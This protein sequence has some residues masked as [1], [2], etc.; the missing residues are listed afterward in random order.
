[1]AVL[2]ALSSPTP[3]LISDYEP[4]WQLQPI[5]GKVVG[6]S[7]GDTITVLDAAKQQHKIRLEGIDAPESNQDYGSRA[8]QSLSDLVFGKVV[9]VTISKKDKY[10]RTLGRVTL[11]GKD[12]GQEQIKRGM[13][14]FYRAYQAELPEN[15]AAMYELGEVRAKA[16]KRGLWA[17]ASPI[18]PWDFRRGKTAKAPGLKPTTTATG[19]IIGNRNSKIYHL[20]NCPDYSKVSE[21]N[22]VPFK[23]EAEAQAAGYRKAKNCP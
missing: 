21:R 12:I 19:A 1:L 3:T 13:A 20:P 22:Q 18:P 5:I 2:I 15:I 4:T 7:D 17:D 23:T 10:G 6:V 16:E 11:D 9:T 8:K 14:W